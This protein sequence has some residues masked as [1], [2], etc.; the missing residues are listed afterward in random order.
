MELQV[1]ILENELWYGGSVADAMEM[2]IDISSKYFLDM[3]CGLNQTMPFFLSTKGRYIWCET[4]M[5]VTV[6]SGVLNLTAPTEIILWDKGENLRD[7]YLDASLQD[8]KHYATKTKFVCNR[9]IR[10]ASADNSFNI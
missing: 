2:P 3:E 8:R 9:N 5:V 4:P 6:E 1:K 7:A 10:S